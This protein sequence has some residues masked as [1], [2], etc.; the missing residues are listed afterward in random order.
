M[1]TTPGTFSRGGQRAAAKG[2]AMSES[3]Q[4]SEASIERGNQRVQIQTRALYLRRQF[5]M[6]ACDAFR[7]AQDELRDG[8]TFDRDGAAN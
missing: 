5:G 1:D 4:P 3:Y 2:E 7:Q 6:L 8:K